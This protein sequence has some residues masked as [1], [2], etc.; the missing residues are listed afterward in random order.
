MELPQSQDNKIR[1][2]VQ[3]QENF[4]KKEVVDLMEDGAENLPSGP[5]SFVGNDGTDEFFDFPEPLDCNQL[6][7]EWPSEQCSNLHSLVIL[8]V[9][10]LP[11]SFS[12]TS[13]FKASSFNDLSTSTYLLLYSYLL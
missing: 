1:V 12:N 10:W 4:D 5:A 7:N 9:A 8:L 6:E 11:L 13:A 2:E 3:N